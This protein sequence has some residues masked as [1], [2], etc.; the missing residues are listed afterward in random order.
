MNKQEI[1]EFIAKRVAK[2]FKD[3]DIVNLG[4]GL[5][6]LVANYVPEDVM[7]TF[8]AENGYTG[9]G[10]APKEGEESPYISNAGGMPASV[11]P[12]GAFF[13]SDV[14]FGLIRGGHLDFTVLG[15]LQV[16]AKANLANYMI[17]GKLVPGMGGAMDLVSGAKQV[18]IAM[19]HTQKGAP[20]ILEECT[21][22]LTGANVV[23]LIIT[24]MAVMKPAEEGM[25]LVEK[26]PE[27]SIEEIEEMT[28][29]KL[30]IPH[31]VKD[32]EI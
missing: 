29:C 28:A 21:L 25:I 27:V 7:V 30:I 22:P 18:I 11:L 10:P 16:D 20:K 17:P 8:Q 14:S 23:D 4:I 12:H 19:E 31:T 26:N 32:M 9:A 6:T 1:K 15:A 2:E 13:G 5:P 3:G 24:E